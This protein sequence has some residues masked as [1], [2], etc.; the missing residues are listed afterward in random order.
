MGSNSRA[1]AAA[2]HQ[3]RRRTIAVICGLACVAAFIG[4]AVIAT[5]GGGAQGADNSPAPASPGTTFPDF[6][7]T[8]L[9]GT[10]VDKSVLTGKKS[11][12]WFTDSTCAPC[13]SGAVKVREVDDEYGGEAFEVVAVFVNPREPE[14]SL[15]SWRDTYARP[16][17]RTA[18]DADGVLSGKVGLKYLDTKYLLDERGEVVDVD[19]APVDAAYIARLK[20]ELGR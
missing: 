19:S 17:W 12:I 3:Q 8:E 11:L 14:T 20:K 1:R 15:R 9:D 18:Y 2:L 7:L 16:D 4:L 6:T 10:K 13:Q 5:A